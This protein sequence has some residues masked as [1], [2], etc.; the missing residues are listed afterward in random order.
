MILTNNKDFYEKLKLLRNHEMI[1]KLDKGK[2]YYEIEKPGFN[3]RITAFQCALGMSQLNK[4]DKFI[5]KRREIVIKY[6]KEFKD[7]QEIITPTEKSYAKSAW[8]IYVIQLRLEKLKVGRKKIFEA[9]QENG[10][11]VQVHYVPL[12]FQPFYKNRFGY[13]KGYFPVV[14]RYYERAITLPLF[15]KMTD[16]EFKRTVRIVKKVINSYKV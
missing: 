12:H 8:H 16:E 14:E 7:I 1:K 11:G 10:L 9:L 6:N 4:L 15:P 13:K 2:W 3:Y 5:K